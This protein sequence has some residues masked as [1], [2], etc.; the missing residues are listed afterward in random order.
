MVHKADLSAQRR[1]VEQHASELYDLQ[2]K[3]RSAIE[4]EDYGQATH[5]L[6]QMAAATSACGA[7]IAELVHMVEAVK[8]RSTGENYG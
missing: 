3:V 6:Q 1:L 4:D 5:R 2:A 8:Q 7:E